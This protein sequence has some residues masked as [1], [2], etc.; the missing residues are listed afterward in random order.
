MG[1]QG[2]SEHSPRLERETQ[3]TLREHFCPI[4]QQIKYANKFPAGHGL[5]KGWGAE[6]LPHH[7]AQEASA[8]LP[9]YKPT[10][11]YCTYTHYIP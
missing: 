6:T 3:Q 10:I 9:C 5:P 4:H 8:R 1:K 11:L 7:T 2:I